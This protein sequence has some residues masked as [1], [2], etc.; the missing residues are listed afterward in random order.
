MITEVVSSIDEITGQSFKVGF[1]SYH[2]NMLQYFPEEF[3]E[4]APETTRH[5]T[6]KY[7]APVMGES[8]EEIKAVYNYYGDHND[9]LTEVFYNG[10][11]VRLIDREEMEQRYTPSP[12]RTD[13][14]AYVRAMQETY[15]CGELVGIVY[16]SQVDIV[17]PIEKP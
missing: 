15:Y 6:I 5:Y 3:V 11:A 1:Y 4:G 14:D 7:K 9:E 2:A 13:N 17:I 10:K 8:V 12:G 16:G